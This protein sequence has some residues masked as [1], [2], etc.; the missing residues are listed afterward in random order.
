MI[1]RR[2][3]S[4]REDDSKWP[5]KNKDGRQELEIR[6]GNEHISFEASII[7][8]ALNL[9]ESLRIPLQTA[10]IGSLTDVTESADPEGL[11]VF[12]YLVQDLKGLVF[13]LISLHFKVGFSSLFPRCF[14]GELVRTNPGLNLDQTDLS[15]QIGQEVTRFKNL[16]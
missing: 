2:L 15:L 10:K 4:A 3:F 11:R 6:M 12:Y 16:L 13:S 5:E 14:L 9:N 1:F 7:D 8:R